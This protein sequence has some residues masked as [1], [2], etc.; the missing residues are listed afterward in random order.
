MSKIDDNG[1]FDS[2]FMNPIRT[3]QADELERIVGGGVRPGQGL[4]RYKKA[5]SVDNQMKDPN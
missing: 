4:G 2:V 1:S 5:S 3:M